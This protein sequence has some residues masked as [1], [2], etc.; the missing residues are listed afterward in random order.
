MCGIVLDTGKEPELQVR[1]TR[2][3]VRHIPVIRPE[4]HLWS[5]QVAQA[6]QIEATNNAML[7]GQSNANKYTPKKK[8]C[9]FIQ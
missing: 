9:K 5:G 7:F 1:T 3:L 6:W 8:T 2:D 4:D